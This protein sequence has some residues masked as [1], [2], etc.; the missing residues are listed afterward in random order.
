MAC[1]LYYNYCVLQQEIEPPPKNTFFGTGPVPGN[2]SDAVIDLE[3]L[4]VEAGTATTRPV[5][6][7][8]KVPVAPVRP[9]T[10]VPKTPAANIQSAF[11]KNLDFRRVY[12]LFKSF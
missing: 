10:R 9:V 1:H 8:A 6:T 7:A 3:E 4:A 12:N 2:D 5:A 11:A